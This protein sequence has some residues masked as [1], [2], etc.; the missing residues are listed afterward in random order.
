M[1]LGEPDA[2]GPDL[3]SLPYRDRQLIAVVQQADNP[4][5]DIEVNISDFVPVFNKTFWTLKGQIELHKRGFT[6]KAWTNLVDKKFLADPKNWGL[7][8]YAYVKLRG[9]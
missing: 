3:I 1:P 6:K 2:L 7:F 4:I 9:K 8:G 5:E